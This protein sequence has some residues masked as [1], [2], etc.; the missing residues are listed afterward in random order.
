MTEVIAEMG[1]D[2]EGLPRRAK[3]L[4]SAAAD[5]H[6]DWVKTQYYREGLRGPNRELPRL[7][8]RKMKDL[9]NYCYDL[10]IKFLVTAHD[11]W[12]IGF[13]L[14]DLEHT[15][16]KLGSGGWHL[17]DKIPGTARLII[18]TGMHTPQEVE[19][20]VQWACERPGRTTILHCV[21]EYPCPADHAFLENIHAINDLITFYET[22]TDRIDVGYSDHTDT[23]CIP[24][25]AVGM[26][27]STIEK[28]LTID[29]Y[30]PERQDTYCSLS[31]H[32]FKIF[33]DRIREIDLAMSPQERY[34]TAGEEATI[35][36][37]KEREKDHE[38][39]N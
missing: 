10:G 20:L 21:S 17:K 13:I 26:G 38:K 33:C 37:L 32:Y 15:T 22:A 3:K 2:H 39:A 36:W 31:P 27:A 11:E 9:N 8:E 19:D 14:H 12:A 18:S 6:A 30:V 29:R 16:I 24:L 4:V 23:M 35:K 5:A 1:V 25:A 28:H 7:T 34:I